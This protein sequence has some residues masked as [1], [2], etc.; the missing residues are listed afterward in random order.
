[1]AIKECSH[2]ELLDDP[3]GGDHARSRKYWILGE[4]NR[5]PTH[6][7][8]R[9]FLES[10][11]RDQQGAWRPAG[12]RVLRLRSTSR[13]VRGQSG[14]ICARIPLLRAVIE[15]GRTRAFMRCHFLRVRRRRHRRGPQGLA[16]PHRARAHRHCLI[17]QAH[18]P[19]GYRG[20]R[21]QGPG[22][23][24]GAV[25]QAEPPWPDGAHVGTSHTFG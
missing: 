4:D 12:A 8:V 3:V 18:E 23:P 19:A 1:M 7:G 10:L 24:M 14:P 20:A 2:A 16:V 25:A 21:G 5:L 11:A 6:A 15:L 13:P 17:R 22:P 9:E